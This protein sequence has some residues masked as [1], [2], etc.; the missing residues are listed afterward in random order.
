MKKVTIT[1][2]ALCV[3][4]SSCSKFTHR[5]AK[6]HANKRTYACPRF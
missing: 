4:M 3:L 6:K 5:L 1:V 2:L